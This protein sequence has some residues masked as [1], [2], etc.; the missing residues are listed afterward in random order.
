MQVNLSLDDVI[1]H[2]KSKFHMLVFYGIVASNIGC[3]HW[4][5]R[6]QKEREAAEA[7]KAIDYGDVTKAQSSGR[8]NRPLEDMPLDQVVRIHQSER[9]EPLIFTCCK[10]VVKRLTRRIRK[11]H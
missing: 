1:K 4:P 6:I 11:I 10:I 9:T 7:A 2:D 5:G 3:V 8:R